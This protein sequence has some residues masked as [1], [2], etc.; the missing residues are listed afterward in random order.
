[1]TLSRNEMAVIAQTVLLEAENQDFQGK[2]AVAFVIKNRMDKQKATAYTICW[3]PWQFSCWLENLDKI[4][5]R[6]TNAPV[7]MIQDSWKA[8][9]LAIDESV[10]DPTQ[11]ATHYL[12]IEVTKQQRGGSLPSWAE[13]LTHTATIGDHDFYKE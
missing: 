4:G 5:R 6:M 10:A 2:L 13:K 11:G 7:D 3:A 9:E 12:N 8:A 1:M